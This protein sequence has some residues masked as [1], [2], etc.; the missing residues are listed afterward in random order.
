MVDAF[1]A[2]HPDVDPA[3]LRWVIRRPIDPRWV[4]FDFSILRRFIG[5]THTLIYDYYYFFRNRGQQR[6]LIFAQL[7]GFIPRAVHLLFGG[8]S[9]P[10]YEEE[11]EEE[12]LEEEREFIRITHT[13]L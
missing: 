6:M 2:D 7:F 5:G 13:E 1:Y 12:E 9:Q 10:K 4:G 3:V 11:L 8:I